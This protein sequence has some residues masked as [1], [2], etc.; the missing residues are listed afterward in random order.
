MGRANIRSGDE[1][2]KYPVANSMT[3]N[4]D[5]LGTFMKSWIVGKKE[6]CLCWDLRLDKLS[7]FSTKT[8]IAAEGV[9]SKYSTELKHQ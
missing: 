2:V 6:C 8:M 9:E 4:L 1:L 5:M 7:K 3:I